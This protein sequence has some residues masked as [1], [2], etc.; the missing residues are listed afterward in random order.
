MIKY[1]ETS[2]RN[3]YSN[4]H[5]NDSKSSNINVDNNTISNNNMF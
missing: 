5:D 3:K 4:D 1:K 2:R